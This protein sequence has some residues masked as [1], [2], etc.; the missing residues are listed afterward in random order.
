[1]KTFINKTI[2][3]S[4]LF[5]TTLSLRAGDKSCSADFIYSVDKSIS[6][7]TYLFVDKS[8]ANGSIISWEWNFGD[9]RN[10]E[11]QNP[12]HQ[13][14]ADGNYIVSLQ[15]K[16]ADGSSDIKYD[17]I[18]VRTVVPPSCTAFFTYQND[19][20]NY[21]NKLFFD[22]SVS[23]GDTI[24]SRTWDFGDGNSQS[25]ITNPIH[26]YTAAGTYYV[27]LTISTSN[28][29]I[30]T[31][32]DSVFV[33]STLPAC[34]AD[35]SFKADSVSG[36]PNTLFFYDH[37]T[38]SSPIVKWLWHFADGDSSTSQ[39]PA[40]IFPYAGIYDVH[41]EIE[42]Q[43]GCVS[44][45]HYPILVGNPQRYNVWGRVYVGNLTTDKCIAYLYKEYQNGYIVP[46]DTVR[47]TSVSD[48][49]GVYYF[50]QILEGTHKVKVLLPNT[51]THYEDYAPTYYGDNL[52]WNQAAYLNLFQDISL[53]N[54]QMKEVNAPAGGSSQISGSV[55]SGNTVLQKEGVQ[56]M[57]LDGA[58]QVY[59]YTYTNSAGYYVFDDVPTGVYFVFAELTGLFSIPGQ[60]NIGTYDTLSYVNIMLSKQQ[61]VTSISKPQEDK[62]LQMKLYPNPARN[63]LWIQMDTPLKGSANYEVLNSLGQSM[64]RGHM[65][66]GSK[67]RM[68]EIQSLESGFYVLRFYN[69]SGEILQNKKFIKNP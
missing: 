54:I 9:G 44:Q 17:T 45:I 61:A 63:T 25:N 26:Q 18:H 14:L 49:L 22:H 42:T 5:F 59:D 64:M 21:L 65:E 33:N 58:Q 53:A 41:L 27:S 62:Q 15:I 36:N 7:F 51:S 10:S 48:T 28:G 43:N 16:C 13:Y 56:I 37:S 34:N 12:E 66:Q 11:Q 6:S 55:Y 52:F 2:L 60:V 31:Y 57:L 35:F 46:V 47:L 29:C 32:G 69:N 20:A 4:I 38:A 1:M 40:H 23:P 68:L 24:V 8:T 3:F 19:S 67:F 50:Y 39:S 30:A